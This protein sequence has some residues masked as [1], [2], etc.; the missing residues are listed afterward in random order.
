MPIT[1][2][3]KNWTWVLERRCPECGFDS[4]AVEFEQLPQLVRQNAASWRPVFARE[5]V[6]VRPDDATWSNL[7]YGAHVR[8]VFR[9]FDG[10]LA[11][12]L[13]EDD[14]AF[15][16]WDQDATA[17]AER[18]NEQDPAVVADELE[19]AAASVADAFARVATEQLGRTGRRSDGSTF[20]VE[21]LGKYFIHDPVHHLHDVG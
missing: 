19:A 11:L 1:P 16:N 12:M 2:D 6:R 8:D 7:E 5:S 15:E 21:T 18:Y 17:L 3:T 10:R 13:R 14:P 4:S 20:T 9:V